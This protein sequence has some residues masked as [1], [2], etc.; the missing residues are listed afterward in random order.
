VKG[1]VDHRDAMRAIASGIDGIVVSNH[2]GRTLD[3]LPATIEALP[4]IVSTVDGRVPVLVDGGIRRGTDVLKCLALGAS[5]VMVGQPVMHALAV[6]GAVGVAHMLT[7]LRAEL[8]AAM[9]LTGC[10]TLADIDGSVLWDGAGP[11]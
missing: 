11:K 7:I 3:T 5:A 9:A 2:G 6:A 8:E 4:R 10:R 1:I